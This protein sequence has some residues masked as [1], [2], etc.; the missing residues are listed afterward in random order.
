MEI[1]KQFTQ[2]IKE[3]EGLILKVC[4]IYT[5]NADDRADLYQEI[6]YQLWKSFG[7][8]KAK[9]KLSTWMYRVAMNTA[10]YFLKKEKKEIRTTSLE[11]SFLQFA[12]ELDKREEEKIQLLYQHI[13][14]L[15][16]LERG[17]ILLYL[18]SKSHEEIAEVMGL[19]TTNVGT[20][21][22]RIREKLKSQI[23]KN[24]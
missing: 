12:E 15:S 23:T 6:V 3:N 7:S 5:F 24:Q 9:A 16:L 4:S 8:Y 11:G 20:R 17:I 13:Q 18:E 2:V 14:M 10:I 19:S 22:S 1:A 21:L